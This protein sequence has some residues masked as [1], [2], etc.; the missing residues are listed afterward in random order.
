MFN[1]VKLQIQVM[2]NDEKIVIFWFRRDLRLYDNHGLFRALTSG[3]PVVP[4]FIFDTN[5]LNEFPDK[6]DRRVSFI[7]KQLKKLQ[8]QIA[9]LGSKFLIC[10]GDPV[11]VFDQITQKFNI[12]AVYTNEDYEPYAIERDA[13]VQKLLEKRGIDYHRFQDHI[14]FHP[15]EVHT[16]GGKPYQIFTSF[17]NR[18]QKLLQ[19]KPVVHYESEKYLY[20]FYHFTLD[21]KSLVTD[22]SIIGYKYVQTQIP[23]AV[24]HIEKIRRYH[25]T[26]DFPYLD[27]TTNLGIHFR[28]G[29][30]SIREAVTIGLQLNEA[31]LNELIWR[32]FFIHLMYH[33]P[34]TM[35]K[36]FREHMEPTWVNSEKHFRAWCEGRTGY[37][38][39][40]A[41]MRQLV[42]SGMMHNRVRMVSANFLTKILRIHWKHGERF[43]AQYLLDFELASNVGNW[44]WAAGTG[45]DAVPYFR[46]F[47][48]V[49]QQQKFDP[50]MQ[51]CK[52][53][54]N[55]DDLLLT[56]IVCFDLARLAYLRQF[57]K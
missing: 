39:I 42:Q 13:K 36:S 1:F 28:F 9:E 52:K 46:I 15:T 55:A 40:D 53:W 29:T 11:D 12:Q 30:I 2:M 34:I 50:H 44:Q 10:Y 41:G 3:L 20:N 23:D 26:R 51:Y 5:I 6:N 47:N 24:F 45:V 7:W 25:L 56:P 31:W 16:D 14:I 32:E 8:E 35:E 43:F 19:N 22:L 49:L 33:Y 48:P 18:W 38:L 27:G 21:C 4:V 57:H 17:K 37:P 54:L